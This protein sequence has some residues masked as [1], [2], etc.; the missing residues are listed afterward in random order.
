MGGPAYD[1]TDTVLAY[2]ARVPASKL[3]LGVPYYGRAWSTD[4]DLIHATNT[5]GTKYGASTT[6]IY[7]TGIGV[8]QEHG[9]RYDTLEATAW[10]AYRRENCSDTYGCVTSWRQLYLDDAKALKAK[11][12]LIN[13]QGLRGAG[14]WALG[15]DEARP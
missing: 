8:L 5:S 1:I 7:A 3:I 9:K 10:T 15:Y 11:Y 14:I 4:S 2:K 6:V 13:S 12:D